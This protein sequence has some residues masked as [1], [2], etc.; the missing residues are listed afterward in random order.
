MTSLSSLPL[1]R[2]YETVVLP[3]F[4]LPSDLTRL[5]WGGHFKLGSDAMAYC[6]TLGQDEYVLVFEDYPGLAE[7]EINQFIAPPGQYLSRQLLYGHGE[8]TEYLHFAPSETP[9]RYIMNV[10]GSFSLFMLLW[11]E[12]E[13][14]E[15]QPMTITE[16]A[17]NLYNIRSSINANSTSEEIMNAGSY[18]IGQTV[19]N[20]EIEI[21]DYLDQ[22]PILDDIDSYACH[23]AID[24][25][26]SKADRIETWKSLADCI[27][28]FYMQ[29][30]KTTAS[31]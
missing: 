24:D 25:S 4:D 1:E 2:I 28:K 16:V 15:L 12:Q 31:R 22:Y 7:R 23:V 3:Q 17:Q 27:E 6:F 19:A 26:E 14:S 30:S 20:L 8:E 9:Y 5:S 13:K 29:V 21:L 18:V 10:T 11:T